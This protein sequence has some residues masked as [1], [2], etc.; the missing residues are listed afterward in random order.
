[1]RMSTP[2]SPEGRLARRMIRSGCIFSSS[3][4]PGWPAGR[5][6]PAEGARAR[7]PGERAGLPA[8]RSIAPGC[9]TLVSPATKRACEAGA[10]DA[11]RRSSEPRPEMTVAMPC[12]PISQA[13]SHGAADLARS[14]RRAKAPGRASVTGWRPEGGA[15]GVGPASSGGLAL[16]PGALADLEALLDLETRAFAGDRL[17]RRSLRRLLGRPS[18]HLIVAES[19]G[20]LV[21]YALVLFRQRQL[22]GAALLDRAG[23]RD[24]T[25]RHRRGRCWRR[26]SGLRPPEEPR[27]SISRSARTTPTPCI[28]TRAVAI[29]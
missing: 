22:D 15:E 18:A 11:G 14:G 7:K 26:R 6:L 20:R 19:E 2:R 23:R 3:V 29:G 27:G 8:A 17:S 16:R 9:L 10:R 24:G 4:G 5:A 12:Q 13:S 1:M 25:A 21:G 28:F